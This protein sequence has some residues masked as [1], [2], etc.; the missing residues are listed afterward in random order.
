M[1]KTSI[2]KAMAS[3]VIV[4]S[5]VMSVFGAPLTVVR[6]AGKVAYATVMSYSGSTSGEGIFVGTNQNAEKGNEN[7]APCIVGETVSQKKGAI[8][9]N[10]VGYI[11][12]EIDRPDFT[13][14][15]AMLKLYIKSVN[16]NLDGWM[17]LACYRTNGAPASAVLGQGSSAAGYP[18][19]NND[20]SYAAASWSDVIELSSWNSWLNVDVTEAVK[21]FCEEQPGADKVKVKFRLQVPTAGVN[22]ATESTLRPKIEVGTA[23]ELEPGEEGEYT[24]TGLF[25]HNMLSDNPGEVGFMSRYEHGDFMTERGYDGMTFSLFEAAQYGLLWDK[26]DQSRGIT[27]TEEEYLQNPSS[28]SVTQQNNKKVFPYGSKERKWVEE[29]RGEII[30]MYADAKKA[31]QKVYFM[32]DV[33]VLPTKLKNDRSDIQSS[34]KIDIRKAETQKVMDFM[35]EEMFTDPDFCDESGRSLIDGI[36]IRYGETYTGSSWGVPYHTGNNPIM[37]D[38]T[39]THLLL[40]NYLRDKICVGL[41][42][43]I[44]YRTWGFGAFQYDRSTYLTISDQLEPH[45][46]FYFAIKH[47][48]GDFHRTFTFNQTL[49]VGKHKQIVEVQAGRE[50]EGKGAFPN[51]IAGGVIN[52]FE[53]Y[54][55][56]MRANEVQS[57]KDVIN[58]PNSLIKGIWTW[59][60]GGGWA[61]PYIN[62]PGYPNSIPD[63]P[64]KDKT[65]GSIPVENGSELWCD[66]NS[67]VI[68]KWAKD[69]SVSDEELVKDYAREELHMNE[70][71]AQSFYELCEKSARAVLL[72]RARNTNAYDVDVWWTRDDGVNTGSF[73]N[74]VKNA[75]NKSAENVMLAEKAESVEL[76]KEMMEIADGLSDD[77]YNVKLADSETSVKDYII[78]TT[79]Y[80][81]HLFD[82]FYQM[83][84][85][86]VENVK[87]QTATP[88]MIRAVKEYS[89]LWE[90]WQKE[91]D[92]NKSKGYP[93]LYAKTKASFNG[94]NSLVYSEPFDNIMGG[95]LGIINQYPEDPGEKLTPT[96][97]ANNASNPEY[98]TDGDVK[99]AFTVTFSSENE[100]KDKYILFEFRDATKINT[101]IIKK[102]KLTLSGNTTYWADHAYAVGCVLEGSVDGENWET[103]HVMNTKPDGTDNQSMVVM[104]FLEP[105]EYKYVRYIRKEKNSYI[106]WA[107][108]GGNKLILAE[109]EFYGETP[110]FHAE[111]IEREE[112]SVTI[113]V[114][115]KTARTLDLIAAVYSEDGELI[116]VARKSVDFESFVPT[117]IK[118]DVKSEGK[119]S[120]FIWDENMNPITEKLTM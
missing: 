13:K 93:T 111:I 81:Y 6:A 100:Y 85:A 21:A 9:S 43:E 102:Q 77:L 29:K 83:H 74:N 28:S 92:D 114:K 48:N 120:V 66:L 51:Y 95:Y 71:D 101:I 2:S 118:L 104:N 44:I 72:G 107:E 31:G 59:S 49:N 73:R 39:Q 109:I 14:E 60:R 58:V 98:A 10:R 3:L 96:A 117:E 87:A 76:W 106:G 4:M 45:E 41:D 67:Y 56:L 40:M 97:K 50:Y 52:G 63:D 108:A 90:E 36:Y 69:T 84:I 86:E 88:D 15:K 38:S 70:E 37:G 17:K 80:G 47:T 116:S 61:G 22:I 57:L 53:E 62:G 105:K 65:D 42:K 16:E 55:F 89:R 34:G 1:R 24:R 20:Y 112:G 33:I 110:D 25:T 11:E 26:Y 94:Y 32:Q 91:Y 82:I 68:N 12:F 8:Y 113:R 115:S 119:M 46:N 103:I 35:Y 75:V 79:S 18:A 64:N 78:M 54:S 99:T 5:M 30:K 19:V 7:G 27:L 23:E